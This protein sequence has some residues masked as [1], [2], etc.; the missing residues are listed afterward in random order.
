MGIQIYKTYFLLLFYQQS[1][2]MFEN[3][4]FLTEPYYKPDIVV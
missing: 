4:K 3:I 2:A 1:H